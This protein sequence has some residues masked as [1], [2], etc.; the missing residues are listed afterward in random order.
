[1]LL[2]LISIGLR[3]KNT[4]KKHE[5][6]NNLI[7]AERL[8]ELCQPLS[9]HIYGLHVL[10]RHSCPNAPRIPQHFLKIRHKQ[11]TSSK[12][13]LENIRPW[14]GLHVINSSSIA[15]HANFLPRDG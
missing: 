5:L 10:H 6:A 13:F 11:V 7:Q 8:Q 12:R 2:K 3:G 15:N 14:V 1:M 4:T 9:C